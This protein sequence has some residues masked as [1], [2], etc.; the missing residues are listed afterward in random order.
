MITIISEL[1]KPHLKNY[2]VQPLQ[3]TDRKPGLGKGRSHAQATK[4]ANSESLGASRVHS[5]PAHPVPRGP[6]T[7]TS[8][9]EED[10]AGTPLLAPE[11]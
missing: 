9:L 5:H 6:G 10:R 11:Q 2:L 3:L 1:I 7:R 4:E 8:P